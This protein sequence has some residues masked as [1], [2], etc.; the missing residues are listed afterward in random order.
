[1]PTVQYGKSF[2][3]SMSKLD[4]EL[5]CLRHDKRKDY[6]GGR[7][8]SFDHFK[9]IVDMVWNR[10]ESVRKHVWHEWGEWFFKEALGQRESRRFLGVAGCGSSSKSDS[11]ALYAIIMYLS[12]PMDTTVLLTS[13][14]L[15]T[16][17]SRVWKCVKEYWS[18]L[19]RYF[20]ENK[21]LAPGKA[22]HSKCRIRGIDRGGGFTDETGLILVPADRQKGEDATSKLQGVK[23]PGKGFMLLVAD[24]LTDL[25]QNV[26]TVA[27]TN[28]TYNYEFQMVALGNPNRKLDP[29][30]RFC[31]PKKGW[32]SIADEPDE[33]ETERGKVIRFNAEKSPRIL[34]EESW[35]ADQ[36]GK[37]QPKCY[38]MPAQADLNA[39][40]R[41]YGAKSLYY[42]RNVK[43]MF[44][45]DKSP[46]ALYSEGELITASE[47]SPPAWDSPHSL[48]AVSGLDSSFT[49]GG[50]KSVN[51]I[52][53]CG[54][55]NSKPHL[56]V[57]ANET[58]D[59]DD[60]K[61][62]APSHQ[63][64]EAW[65]ESCEKHGVAAKNAGFDG[66][67]AGVSFGSIV[68]MAWSPQ[69]IPILFGGKP[70]GRNMGLNSVTDE[71]YA[72]RVSELWLQIK[73]LLREKQ[74]TGL[75]D[76]I[77]EDLIS[78]EYDK[79]MEQRKLKIEKKSETKKRINR[80]TDDADAFLIAV[81]VAIQ[82]G[83]LDSIEEKTIIRREQTKW[84]QNKSGLAA[85]FGKF[86]TRQLR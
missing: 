76:R 63:V 74:I 66:S 21:A 52:A 62:L 86:K 25:A 28:L 19:E 36:V 84:R 72:N 75:T 40:A 43:G 12:A 14:T 45:F 42:Y 22:V 37:K 58:I 18:E 56:H 82:N 1:M 55:V 30:G 33:W 46:N 73:P 57:I 13:L 26:L 4:I 35:P 77:V 38:W 53:L 6:E 81:E 59:I 24:E 9:N 50:D 83:L 7:L 32:D 8:S 80:S 44:C 54:L 5:W 3:D 71:E 11:A 48:V 16:A 61:H 20:A 15:E 64:V 34:E 78:R 60:K 2:P 65:K 51:V 85:R 41:D 23:A 17:K 69:V 27:Y 29:F 67:G 79:N 10:K 68:Q 70:S 39:I 49:S 47:Q 31:T